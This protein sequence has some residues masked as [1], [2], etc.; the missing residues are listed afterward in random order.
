MFKISN[1]KLLEL[2]K[3]QNQEFLFDLIYEIIKENPILELNGHFEDLVTPVQVLINQYIEKGV[4]QINTLK[5][6]VKSHVYLG[7]DYDKDPQFDWIKMELDNYNIRDQV[8]YVDAF[9]NILEIYK[10]NV[11]GKNFVFMIDAFYKLKE[12]KSNS[13]CEI[14]AIDIYPQKYLFLKGKFQ[15][16]Y[17]NEEFILGENFKDNCFFKKIYKLE[18]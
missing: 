7:M 5:Y 2:H 1:E 4:N 8:T 17:I 11:L 9:F 15:L 14:N 10:K 12:K 18:V 13:L 3:A 6:M 16:S